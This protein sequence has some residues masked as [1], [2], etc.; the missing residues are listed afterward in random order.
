MRSFHRRGVYQRDGPAADAGPERV[1]R[2][3]PGRRRRPPR[4]RRRRRPPAGRSVACGSSL[5]PA[6]GRVSAVALA[7]GR[8]CR[9][10]GVQP[11]AVRLTCPPPKSRAA[12]SSRSSRRAATSGRSV[13]ARHRAVPGGR[14]ADP[15]ARAER[16]RGQEGRRRREVRRGDAA[17]DAAGPPVRAAAGAGRTGSGAR[18][19]QDHRGAGPHGGD[20]GGLRR[21]AREARPRRSRPSRPAMDVERTKLVARRRAAAARRSGSD[22]IAPTG[23]RRKR[24][25]ARASERSPRSAAT[26]TLAERALGSLQVTAP[27]D[28]TVSIMPN[29]RA[30]SPMGPAQEFRAGDRAW[31]GAQILE[32]PDLTSIHLAS[33]IDEAD[34]GQL[35]PGQTATIRVD[36]VPDR[37]Y[38]GTIADISMLA[39]VDFSSGWPPSKNFDLKLTIKDADT[40][41]KPGMSAVARIAVGKTPDLLLIPAGAVFTAEGRSVVYRRTSRGFDETPID[42]VRRAREQVAIK[43]GSSP[44]TGSPSRGRRN[45]RS[46]AANDAPALVGSGRRGGR[47]RGASAFFAVRLIG[48]SEPLA[49]RAGGPLIPT[50]RITPRA[51]GAERQRHR[52]GARREVGDAAGAVGRRH[53]AHPEDGAHGHDG[54]DRRRHRRA[55]S[56]PSRSTRSSRRSPSSQQAEQEIVKRKADAAVQAAQDKVELLTARFDVRRAQLDG[57]DRQGPDR[58][59]AVREAPARARGDATAAR[60]GRGRTSSRAPRRARRRSRSSRRSAPRPSSPPLARSRTSTAW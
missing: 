47:R 23:R 14:T 12:T 60:A 53:A 1:G 2:D 27:A 49:H 59:H 50:T 25:W 11:A 38:Q 31:P 13:D 48:S 16:I 26:S 57:A 6:T 54:Q 37:E 42:I 21:P 36:A 15:R 18:A 46:E 7:V 30:S 4:P 45:M 35:K 19:G 28:G 10:R 5:P 52:R 9:R 33:R 41:I 32:L 43:R 58:R 44:A 40:K 34:R 56:R 8:R 29:F 55:R 39:R 51:A 22:A 20:Q 24:T 3:R 17:A